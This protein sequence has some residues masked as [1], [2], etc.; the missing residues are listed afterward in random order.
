MSYI[1]VVSIFCSTLQLNELLLFSLEMWGMRMFKQRGEPTLIKG[2]LLVCCF[3]KRTN[4]FS[5]RLPHS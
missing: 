3:P 4:L 5:V 1:K 2:D